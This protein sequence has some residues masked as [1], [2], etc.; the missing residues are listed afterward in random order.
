[1]SLNVG[2][3]AEELFESF[4]HSSN[5]VVVGRFTALSLMLSFMW[6]VDTIKATVEQFNATHFHKMYECLKTRCFL[7]C[8][9]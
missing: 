2:S 8:T 9:H 6:R 5:C 4:L 3:S 7:T 1:M